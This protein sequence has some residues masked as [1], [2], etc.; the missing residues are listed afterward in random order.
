MWIYLYI[1]TYYMYVCM[2][3]DEH[4]SICICVC[5]YVGVCMC[6]PG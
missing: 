2:Y 3:I 4:V 1:N 6:V 5:I